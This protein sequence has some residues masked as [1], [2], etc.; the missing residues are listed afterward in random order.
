[1]KLKIDREADA[2]YLALDDSK[3]VESEESVT[4]HRRRPERT[5]PNR[6]H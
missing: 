6:G 1:M 2:L 3:I 5:G 4:R